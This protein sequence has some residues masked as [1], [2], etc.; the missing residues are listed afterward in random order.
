[1]AVGDVFSPKV[2]DSALA[3]RFVSQNGSGYISIGIF[4]GQTPKDAENDSIA[5]KIYFND[6]TKTPPGDLVFSADH[7]MISRDDVGKYSFNMGPELTAQRGLLTA[8]W[9]YEI[10]GKDFKFVDNLEVLEQMPLYERL[11]ADER[12]VVEAVSWM[13]ADAF[14]STEGGPYLFETYQSHFNYERIAQLM[15]VATY[16]INTTGNPPTEFDVGGVPNQY[17]PVP[18]FLKG[19]LVIG[20]YIELL[21]HLVRNYTEI[22]VFQG[23]NITFAD[24]RDYQQRWQSVLQEEQ[25]GFK[26]M[27]IQAKRK[28][29][30]LGSTAILVGGGFWSVGGGGFGVYAGNL[31]TM[32]A[33]GARFYPAAPA[34]Y[35]SLARTR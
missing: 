33:R 22:P 20:T 21:K 28:L 8:E 35:G 30:G 27:V 14:D 16:R 1:M 15:R 12:S 24:R 31:F 11:S 34:I 4:D 5:V 18:P 25:D 7:T 9:A 13:F 17:T 2:S 19:T 29:L 6:G 26:S 23:A 32:Q 3:R 10:N